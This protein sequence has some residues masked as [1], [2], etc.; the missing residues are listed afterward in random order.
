[1]AWKK[2]RAYILSGKELSSNGVG[3]EPSKPTL[4]NT[5]PPTRPY[6]LILPKQFLQ[7]GTKCSIYVL[8][9]A[10]LIQTTTY[11]VHTNT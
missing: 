6:L 7:L 10:T 9:R 4:S 8:M 2:M 3:F 11:T 5:P 1:M